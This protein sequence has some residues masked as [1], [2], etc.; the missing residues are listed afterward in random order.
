MQFKVNR[1]LKSQRRRR[2]AAARRAADPC[3][4]FFCAVISYRFVFLCMRKMTCGVR[5]C[6]K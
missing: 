5:V 3:L 6:E 4:S 1:H 2:D